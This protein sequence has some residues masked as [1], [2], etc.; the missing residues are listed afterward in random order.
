[1]VLSCFEAWLC[2]WGGL[3]HGCGVIA[4]FGVWLLSYY[5]NALPV[6][7]IMIVGIVTILAAF[8][9]ILIINMILLLVLFL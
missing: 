5:R 1:M 7:N 8:D 3:W 9:V 4:L 6:M 2:G